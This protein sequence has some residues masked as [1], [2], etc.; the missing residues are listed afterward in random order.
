[1]NE[2]ACQAALEVYC[3]GAITGPVDGCTIGGSGVDVDCDGIPDT[4]DECTP[5]TVDSNPAC[6]GMRAALYT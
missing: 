5:A 3:P 1:M 2:P 6:N 4:L